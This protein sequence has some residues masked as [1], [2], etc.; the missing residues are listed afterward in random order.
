LIS[1]V[2]F[3]IGPANDDD[4]KFQI[5]PIT[6]NNSTKDWDISETFVELV[7]SFTLGRKTG[8]FIIDLTSTTLS[9]LK[10]LN[11]EP[12]A[13]AA[14]E[15]HFATTSSLRQVCNVQFFGWYYC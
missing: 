14:G 5:Y 2:F 1:S 7:D 11:G 3:Q 12:F 8:N 13:A 4:F 10:G 15:F 9:S 6:W